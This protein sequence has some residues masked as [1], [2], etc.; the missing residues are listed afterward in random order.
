MEAPEVPTEHLH[1]HLEHAAGHGGARW[2]SYV[3]VS[4]AIIAALA[5]IASLLA[6]AHVNEAIVSKMDANDTWSEFGVKSIKGDLAAFKGDEAKAKDYE[7]KKAKLMEHATELGEEAKHHLAIHEQLARAVTLF[8]IAIAIA[9]ISALTKKKP[10]WYCSL[11]F[12]LVGAFF[13]VTSLLSS[14]GHH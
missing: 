7:E 1:E 8:Q 14:S 2:I 5:A 13:L 3:A 4:T 12:G 6:G 9:A 10:F 11:V